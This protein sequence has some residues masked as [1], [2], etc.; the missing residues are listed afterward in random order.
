[1][2]GGKWTPHRPADW[3]ARYATT[4][5]DFAASKFIGWE[6]GEA[7]NQQWT[8]PAGTRVRIV[9]ASR[10][11]D[12]GITDDISAEHG[13]CVRCELSQLTDFSKEPQQ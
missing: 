1:M 6:D 12:V 2:S 11:G 7:C 10:F 5:V 4:L 8:I 13:Y 9:M 3:P